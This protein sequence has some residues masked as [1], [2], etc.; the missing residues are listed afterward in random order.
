[1]DLLVKTTYSYKLLSNLGVTS[2]APRAKSVTF[3]YFLLNF[4]GETDRVFPK[5]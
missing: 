5:N 2:P 4:W 1:M 3:S